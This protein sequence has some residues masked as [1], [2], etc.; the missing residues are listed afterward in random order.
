MSTASWGDA[1]KV[2]EYL[3][4]V[5]TLAPRLAGEAALL[6]VIPPRVERLADLGCGDGR[7]TTVVL[8]SR[9]SVEGSWPS[10]APPRCSRAHAHVSQTTRG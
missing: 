8:D 1:D 6:E 7:L 10:I 3:G 9:A 4:R 2:D 5:G